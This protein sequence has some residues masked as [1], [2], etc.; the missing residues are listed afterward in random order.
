MP[1]RGL[2]RG[3]RN[4]L[5]H[6]RQQYAGKFITKYVY[7]ALPPGVLDELKARLPKN[8]NGDRRAKL[9]QLLTIDTGIEHLD[10]QITADLTLMQ[11]SGNKA[12]FDRH[13]QRL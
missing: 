9:W 10:R 8:E 13:W 7:D 4:V 3:S 11:I 5:E 12:E 6:W 1:S 2:S